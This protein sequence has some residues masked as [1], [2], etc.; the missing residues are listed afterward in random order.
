VTEREGQEGHPAIRCPVLGELSE[1]V[2]VVRAAY[3]AISEGDALALDRLVAPGVVW[4]HPAVS[5]LPFDGTSCGLAAVLA[6]GFHCRDGSVPPFA[7]ET[8]LELGDG[9]LVVGR[10]LGDEGTGRERPFLHECFVRSGRIVTIREYPTD[11][12]RA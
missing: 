10:F 11:D 2:A 7:A 1:D 12:G 4:V 6:G 5:R 8:F 9:V 3:R